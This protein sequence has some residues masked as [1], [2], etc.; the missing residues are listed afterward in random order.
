LYDAFDLVKKEGLP[1][2]FVER[3]NEAIAERRFS[4]TI[5]YQD[6]LP[7]E[8]EQL[9]LSKHPGFQVSRV[10][11]VNDKDFT[12]YK[13]RLDKGEERK[14]LSLDVSGKILD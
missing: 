11:F 10:T 5:P 1:N 9:V 6:P 12:G 8:L 7:K 4:N 2:E 3:N 14:E 13:V